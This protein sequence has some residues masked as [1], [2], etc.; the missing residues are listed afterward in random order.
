MFTWDGWGPW[1]VCGYNLRAILLCK[2][3]PG[4]PATTTDV[5]FPTYVIQFSATRLNNERL[6]KLYL[7]DWPET[8]WMNVMIRPHSSWLM[9]L[10]IRVPCETITV[11]KLSLVTLNDETFDFGRDSCGMVL[12]RSIYAKACCILSHAKQHDWS[13]CLIYATSVLLDRICRRRTESVWLM[14][15]FW[16]SGAQI[17][18]TVVQTPK[19]PGVLY[20]SFLIEHFTRH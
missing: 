12:L 18:W 13:L 16:L 8:D 5:Q 15:S 17:C 2:R 19:V 9:I 7:L 3:P 20:I 11:H 14:R 10:R 1:P 6:S 4:S